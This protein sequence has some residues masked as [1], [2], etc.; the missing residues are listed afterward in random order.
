MNQ[1]IHLASGLPVKVGDLVIAKNGA[2]LFVTELPN[3]PLSSRVQVTD[4]V[5]VC[6]STLITDVGI[7]WEY[8]HRNMI[9]TGNEVKYGGLTF[10]VEFT[11]DDDSDAPWEH[12][13][14]YGIVSDWTLRNK[15]AGERDIA[16][17]RHHKRYYD[18][19]G[20]LAKAKAEGWDAPPYR[21]GTKGEQAVRAV[22]ADFEFLKAW[23]DDEWRYEVVTVTC[24][25][26]GAEDCCGGFETWKD[27]HVEA[28]WQMIEQLAETV[29][30]GMIAESEAAAL[31]SER[32]AKEK[33]ELQSI[34]D[35]MWSRVHAALQMDRY[36]DHMIHQQRKRFNLLCA[37]AGVA[38]E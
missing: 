2:H 18:F 36:S 14:G 37:K 1:L 30:K 3:Y 19:A 31:E 22:E 33:L 28:A 34:A 17:G 24:K 8:P 13:D 38:V 23:L 7:V 16:S 32:A 11:P 27:Y 20:S 6:G 4:K 9:Y 26:T 15:R 35:D 25:E 5:A 12:G 21:T 29:I 10:T